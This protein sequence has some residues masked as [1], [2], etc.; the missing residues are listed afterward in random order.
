[1]STLP[2]PFVPRTLA[3]TLV[4]VPSVLKSAALVAVGAGLLAGL[5]QL[6]IPMWPV[7]ITGQTL[8]VLLVG[9]SL[10]W[11]RGG[12]SMALYLVLGLVGLPV[13]APLADGQHLTGSAWVMAPSFGYAVGFVFAAIAVGWLAEHLRWDRRWLRGV[14]AFAIG[15]VIIY[16]FGLPWLAVALSHLGVPGGQLAT[17]VIATGL[18]PFIIGDVVKALIAGALFPAAWL[19]VRRSADHARP[20]DPTEP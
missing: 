1:M 15:E 6:S 5:A 19:L 18:L 8:G 16:A 11:L 3:D 4:G 2:S 14:L 12:L 20:G 7:P 17:T 13:S 9:A 10:G